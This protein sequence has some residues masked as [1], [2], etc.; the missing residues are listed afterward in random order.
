MVITI[1]VEGGQLVEARL[2]PLNALLGLVTP[3]DVNP[4]ALA[5][6]VAY[7]AIPALAAVQAACVTLKQRSTPTLETAYICLAEHVERVRQGLK[8]ASVSFPIIAVSTHSIAIHDVEFASGRLAGAL[9]G[10]VRLGGPPLRIIPFDHE[11]PREEVKRHVMPALVASLS[12]RAPHVTLTSLTEKAVPHYG[13]Y[14]HKAQNRLRSVVGAAV[15]EIEASHPSHFAYERPTG[16]RP[17]GLVRFLKTPEEYDRPGRTLAYQALG[18]VGRRTPPSGRPE[19]P[20]Q[21]DLLRELDAADNEEDWS[22]MDDVGG[23]S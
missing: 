6:A 18:R 3:S 14:S 1:L 22:M 23:R 21:M 19:S 13:I 17:E 8:A 20:G 5:Q 2:L 9:D 11:S 15:A 10:T 7:A 4:A 12:N 16:S